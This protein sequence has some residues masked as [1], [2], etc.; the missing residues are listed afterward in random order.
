MNQE[1]I[2][3]T[4][5]QIEKT[6][7]TRYFHENIYVQPFLPIKFIVNKVKTVQ[8]YSGQTH[9]RLKMKANILKRLK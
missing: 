5:C 1:G 2:F 9:A 6:S 3:I 8:H 4:C 7:K